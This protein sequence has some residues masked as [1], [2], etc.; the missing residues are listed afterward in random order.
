MSDPKN[1]ETVRIDSEIDFR[2]KVGLTE[3]DT[4]EWEEGKV[5]EATQSAL[6]SLRASME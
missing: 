6:D 2:E 5:V 4:L 3:H 1:K